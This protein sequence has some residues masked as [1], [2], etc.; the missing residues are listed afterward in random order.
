MQIFL[1]EATIFTKSR[2][3]VV[4]FDV[5]PRVPGSSSFKYLPP[6]GVAILHQFY[7]TSETEQ[8]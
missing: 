7:Q 6:M 8:S 1:I 4:P 3:W 5:L 2:N